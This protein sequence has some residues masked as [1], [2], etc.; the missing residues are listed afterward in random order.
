MRTVTLVL[1]VAAT[2]ASTGAAAESPALPPVKRVVDHV[3]DLYRADSSAARLTMKVV[4]ARYRRELALQSWTRGKKDALVVVN[5]PAREAGTATLRT[6]DGLWSYAPRADRLVRIPSSL[7]SDDWMG[8]H[9][10]ND[11]LM[12]ETD[13]TEDYDTSLAWTEEGGRRLLA[14][15]LRPRPQAPVVW[16]Q[17][18]YVLE[19]EDFLPLRADYYDGG[20][21]AR[22]LRFS[23]PRKVNGR[24]VPFVLEMVPLH[25]PGESTKIEYQELALGA[26]VDPEHFTQ[27]GLR[28]GARP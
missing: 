16:S 22:T 6:D 24:R 10:S 11:D 9:F 12:R 27:R 18:V 4:T 5:G 15:T 17:V 23:D 8:S 20:Q 28:R 1:A 19:P 2:L 7:L 25:K 3:N 26:R 13:F 14:A 21:I